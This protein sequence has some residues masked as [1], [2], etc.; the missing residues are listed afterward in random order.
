[1]TST[2]LN[3]QVDLMPESTEQTHP[4][5][6]NP[7]LI[8]HTC[9]FK[10]DSYFA[11]GLTQTIKSS[12]SWMTRGRFYPVAIGRKR[13]IMGFV[14]ALQGDGCTVSAYAALI[15]GKMVSAN[16][17]CQWSP[18]IYRSPFV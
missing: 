7:V 12:N 11:L 13:C 9:T 14:L 8:N 4:P 16:K 2:R 10:S 1:M 5:Q 6:G 18:S 3:S 15:A 17:S